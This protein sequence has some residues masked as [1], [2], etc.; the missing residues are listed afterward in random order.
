M[1]VAEILS[2]CTVPK[3]LVDIMSHLGLKDRVNF[4]RLYID[5]LLAEGKLSMTEPDRPTSRNQK[6]MA[7]KCDG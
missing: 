2:Y 1:K 6:Y 3:S 4:K 7:V 5:P